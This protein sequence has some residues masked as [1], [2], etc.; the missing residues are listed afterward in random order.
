MHVT[1]RG[2][3]KLT[4]IIL[5]ELIALVISAALNGQGRPAEGPM[6]AFDIDVSG[7]WTPMLHEDNL[8][9]GNGPEIADYGG[10]A[11]N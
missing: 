10:F 2:P 4:R 1:M 8:E 7:Y 9:R 6:R 11:L 3:M 5:P